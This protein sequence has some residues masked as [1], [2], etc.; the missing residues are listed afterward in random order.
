MRRNLTR[1]LL[2]TFLATAATALGAEDPPPPP[3]PPPPSGETGSATTIESPTE[4]Q[5]QIKGTDSLLD[6][7]TGHVRKPMLSFFLGIPYGGYLGFGFGFGARF[8][9]P[10][11]KEGFLPMLNDSFGIEFGV[12]PTILF[13][14]TTGV[15]VAIPVEARWNFH[16]FPKLEAYAKVGAALAIISF[17]GINYFSVG[18][19]LV[20]NVGVLF[21]LNSVISLRAEVGYPAI[22]VGIGIAF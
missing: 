10:I 13:W 18:G 3:P 15:G 17:P 9:I 21:R 20:A 1:L 14:T 12:D 22:K 2:L 4:G 11:V 16:I 6:K 7:G 19:I 8:Y 5:W